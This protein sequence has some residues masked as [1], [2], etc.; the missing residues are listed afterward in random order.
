MLIKSVPYVCAAY[1]TERPDGL[2]NLFKFPKVKFM[3]QGEDSKQR[4]GSTVNYSTANIK[5]TYSPLLS[6]GDDCYKRLAVDPKSETVTKWF[7]NADYI[8]GTESAVS[9]DKNEGD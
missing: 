1:A 7:A 4:E 3:P 5:G 2:L 8:G 6:S 9:L